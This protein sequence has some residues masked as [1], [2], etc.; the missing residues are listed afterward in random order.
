MTEQLK[1]TEEKLKAQE[2][3]NADAVASSEAQAEMMKGLCDE[4][5][6]MEE[7][8]GSSEL[9]RDTFVIAGSAI[10]SFQS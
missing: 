6:T 5:K 9:I 3:K 7:V 8:S 1:E 2:S 10:A 4:M